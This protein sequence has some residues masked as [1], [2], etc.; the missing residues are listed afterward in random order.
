M[1]LTNGTSFPRF[2]K[3]PVDMGS[4]KALTF[5]SVF[6]GKRSSCRRVLFAMMDASLVAVEADG[7]CCEECKRAKQG[8]LGYVTR[9]QGSDWLRSCVVKQHVLSKKPARPLQAKCQSQ[10]IHDGHVNRKQIARNEKY[11][12]WFLAFGRARSFSS[13]SARLC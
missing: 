12:L 3:C 4:W 1:K 10:L 2:I 6:D 11:E 9:C 13:R 5:R 8:T 7:R